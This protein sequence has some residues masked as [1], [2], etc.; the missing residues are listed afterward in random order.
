M[1]GYITHGRLQVA[2]QLDSFIND[3]AIPGTH[4]QPESFWKGAEAL[5]ARYLKSV[6]S[7][8]ALS[9]IIINPETLLQAT[10]IPPF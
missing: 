7:Y 10:N 6:N 9:M 3:Q 4:V 2:E 1:Q 8:S 5:F